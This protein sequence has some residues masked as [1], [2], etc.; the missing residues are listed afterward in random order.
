MSG[1][2]DLANNPLLQPSDLPYGAPPLNKIKPAHYLPAFKYAVEQARAEI[3]DIKTNKAA[4]T[5]DNTIVALEQAGQLMD[6][7]ATIFGN[8]KGA[9]ANDELRAIEETI[10]NECVK[11]GNDV[12]L[13]DTLFARVKAVYD[14]KDSMILSGEQARL[15]ERTYQAYARN[16]A[17]LPADKKDELKEVSEKL[18]KLY[19]TFDNNVTLATSAYGK[20]VED[21][22]D[23]RGLPKD[24]KQ[25]YAKFAEKAGHP[26]KWMIKLSPPPVDLLEYCDNRELREE[27]QKARTNIAFGGAHDNSQVVLD[28]MALRQQ[29]AELLGYPNFAEMTLSDR[30]AKDSAT[31]MKFLKENEAV[32]RP[33]ADDYMQKLS[34]YAQKT[35]GVSTIEPWDVLYY[36]RRLKEETYK[37]DLQEIRQ[38]FNLEKVLDGLRAHAEKL[39]NIEMT[40]VKGKYGTYDPDVKVYEVKDKATGDMVGI[41][42][43][44]YYARPGAKSNGAWM[45]T[46]RKR[47]LSVEGE[48]EISLVTNVCNFPKPTDEHP[49]LLSLDDLRTVFHEFGHGLHALLAEGNYR[50]LTCTSVLRDFVELP[51]QLMENWAK[52]KEVLDTFARHD[53]T[54]QQLDAATIK[55]LQDMENFDAGYRGMRQTFFGLLDMKWHTTDPKTIKSVEGF[56]DEVI[57]ESWL[58]KRVAGPQSTSFGHLFGGEGYSA[59]Y[60]GYKWAE[61][62]DA[63]VFSAFEKNGLYDRKTADRLRET[64]YAKGGTEDPAELFK[65]MMGRDP[66]PKALFRREGLLPEEPA[67]ENTPKKPAPKNAFN[68]K[69]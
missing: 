24:I 8:V 69:K 26:G 38:Y 47:G 20:L 22:N 37:V 12:M 29:K 19:S 41:F 10:D 66:D 59:G 35:D 18:A 54:G 33:A 27:V 16:G 53:K 63:D 43:A 61:A 42:Y 55:K 34:A 62:L 30:M 15:L 64:I 7:V 56:E 9:N 3:N 25:M 31:V 17:A 13:D 23:L 57:K 11:F 39:F 58:F 67:N 21:E 60:Y 68:N 28:I 45:N 14:Q 40:E 46:F 44:D 49:T 4:P 65:K 36:G 6:R 50:S 1:K 48:N 5:F 51:S 52:E 2:D 32:Y